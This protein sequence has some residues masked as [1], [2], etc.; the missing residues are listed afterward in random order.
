MPHHFLRFDDGD[1]RFLV[2]EV[3]GSA[4]PDRF[5]GKLPPEAKPVNDAGCG[6]FP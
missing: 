4:G 3:R 5:L 6:S 1:R 2:C